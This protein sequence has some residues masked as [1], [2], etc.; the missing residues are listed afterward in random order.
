V[1]TLILLVVAGASFAGNIPGFIVR[2]DVPLQQTV[3]TPRNVVAVHSR[4]LPSWKC[5]P[6]IVQ[7]FDHS[8]SLLLRLESNSE[9]YAADVSFDVNGIL[10]HVADAPWQQEQTFDTVFE[11]FA[12]LDGQ[13][14][15]IRGIA[16]APYAWVTVSGGGKFRVSIHLAAEEIQTFRAILQKYDS[17]D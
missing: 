6:V 9:I 16:S 10:S 14:K 8:K 5:Y 2:R 4:G 1:K 13:E 15:V 11:S 12:I 7:K 3:I 17:L